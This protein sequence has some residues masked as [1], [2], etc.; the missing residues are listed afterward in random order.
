MATHQAYRPETPPHPDRLWVWEKNVY[1][2]EF[3]RS[4]LPVA[5]KSDGK[6]QVLMY[7]RDVTLGAAMTP[8]QLM[9][10]QLPLM[11]QLYPGEKY[12]S[13]DSMFW[14]ILYHVKFRDVEEMLLELM[15]P[16]E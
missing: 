8:S 14:K 9:P 3:R 10:Y 15:N 16:N 12:R 2:D 11:W 1:L 6:F 4:W 5:I 7:Q 13:C